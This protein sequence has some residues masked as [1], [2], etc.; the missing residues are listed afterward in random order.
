[1]GPKTTGL[2]IV[3]LGHTLLNTDNG[4]NETPVNQSSGGDHLSWPFL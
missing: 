4:L 2:R 1:M 3:A